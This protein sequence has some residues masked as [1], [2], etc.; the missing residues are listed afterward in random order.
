MAQL[1]NEIGTDLVPNPKIYLEAGPALGLGH[2]GHRRRPPTRGR[3]KILGQNLIFI[4]KK[5]E[6]EGKKWFYN[7]TL[8]LRSSKVLSNA[9][10]NTTLNTLVLQIE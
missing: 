3:P 5:M 1:F 7:F 6:I 9:R 2:L 8:L 4:K 10:N